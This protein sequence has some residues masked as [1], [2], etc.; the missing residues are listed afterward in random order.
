VDAGE[1]PL[2][3]VARVVGQHG[4]RGQ[5][6]L[7]A[8]LGGVRRASSEEIVEELARRAAAVTLGGR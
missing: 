4:G 7:A 5:L 6:R 2:A 3:L 8:E 1:S